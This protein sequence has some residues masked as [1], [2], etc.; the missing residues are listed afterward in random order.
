MTKEKHQPELDP[1]YVDKKG[2]TMEEQAAEGGLHVAFAE[3]SRVN[4][5]DSISFEDQEQVYGA[6]PVP[7]AKPDD[8]ETDASE[9]AENVDFEE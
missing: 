1:M 3:D 7:T 8:I 5:P 9:P 4:R 6:V 2:L